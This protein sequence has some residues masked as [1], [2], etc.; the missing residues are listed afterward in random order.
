[1]GLGCGLEK[2]RKYKT[3]RWP[4][5]V[6]TQT[7]SF[8]LKAGSKEIFIKA[9]YSI[10]ISKKVLPVW[11]TI[12]TVLDRPSLGDDLSRFYQEEIS[13]ILLNKIMKTILFY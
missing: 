1:M 11:W 7:F 3:F 5:G 10:S 4:R 8:G 9:F 13:Q 2:I 6:V 12:Q